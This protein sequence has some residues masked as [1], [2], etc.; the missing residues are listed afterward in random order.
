MTTK[1]K[2]KLKFVVNLLKRQKLAE[3]RY[4]SEEFE[5]SSFGNFWKQ[6]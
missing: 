3:H 5:I 4:I 1:L 2:L 6:D